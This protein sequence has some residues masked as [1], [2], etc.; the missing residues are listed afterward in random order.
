M[1]HDESLFAGA[2]P[3]YAR[4]RAP[5]PAQL[6]ADL[7]AHYELDGTGRLLDLGCGPGTLTLPLAPYFAS[8]LAL[9]VNAE[10]ID[11]GRRIAASFNE[12]R[13]RRIEWCVMP[14]EEISPALGT[15]RLVT[16]GSSFHW[17]DRDLVLARVRE[18]LEP[19][20]GIA[21]A[22]GTS[23]WWDGPADWQQALT[24]VVRKYL[25]EW[26]RAGRSGLAR[27]MATG[28]RF[29]HALAR[30][31][32]RVELNRDY[33]VTLERDIDS[34][35]GHL[36]STSFAARPHFGERVDEFEAELRTELLRLHPDG[37][38]VETGE[39]GLVCGRP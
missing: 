29:E 35:I 38:F 19:D 16:C 21:L 14:A 30:N 15:F 37:R 4:Y 12:F 5:Y 10:M 8:V 1:P 33:P 32:W 31:G 24:R 13:K 22:A 11:E 36:W 25:G 20:C 6:I 26:W 7:V 3:Y 39:F 23:G 2:A 9:D 17:M 28:E 18:L 34:L 27:Y